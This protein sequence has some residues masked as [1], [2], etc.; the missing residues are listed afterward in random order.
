MVLVN[1]RIKEEIYKQLNH[2][3]TK[4]LLFYKV[5]LSITKITTS[6]FIKIEVTTWK[7]HLNVTEI[8][9]IVDKELSYFNLIK[10]KL[11]N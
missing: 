1:I 7:F 8:V 9:I 4:I 2:L 3:I 11:R 5:I 6:S 10:M